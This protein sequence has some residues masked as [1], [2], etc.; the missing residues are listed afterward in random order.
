MQQ[1]KPQ[2]Q[3]ELFHQFDLNKQLG[4][5]TVTR[6]EDIYNFTSLAT[7]TLTPIGRDKLNDPDLKFVAK[8]VQNLNDFKLKVFRS[9]KSH[10]F[11]LKSVFSVDKAEGANIGIF[12]DRHEISFE[13]RSKLSGDDSPWTQRGAGDLES[14]DIQRILRAGTHFFRAL[15]F[16]HEDPNILFDEIEFHE[17]SSDSSTG[18]VKV[19]PNLFKCDTIYIPY[20]K[21]AQYELQLYNNTKLDLYLSVLMFNVCDLSIGMPSFQ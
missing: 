15:Y 1:I 12:W 9:D 4:T 16:R 10:R 3:L 20:K 5:L 21:D 11:N 19:G 8:E 7:G 13:I 6:S 2:C 17:V 18:S 14:D